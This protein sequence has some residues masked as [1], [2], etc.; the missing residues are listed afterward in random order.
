MRVVSTIPG[1]EPFTLEAGSIAVLMIHGF[2]GSPLSVKPWAQA[3]HA[4]GYTV[5]VPRLPGH[6]Q[7][8]EA[9]NETSWRDWY[10][11]VLNSFNSL[12]ARH[13]RVFVAGFSMGGALALHLAAKKGSE[14]EGLLLANPSVHDKRPMMRLVP[15]LKYFIPSVAGRGTDVAAP[16]PPKHSYGR[17]PL[18][19]LSS[20]Q[21]LWRIVQSELFAIDIPLMIGYSINDHVV[22]PANSETVIDNIS[23]VD[24]REVIFERSFHNVALDHDL[25]LLVE[26]ST[27]FISDVLTGAIEAPFDERELIDAEFEEIVA[28]FD[29]PSASAMDSDYIDQLEQIEAAERYTGDNKALPTLTR[30]QRAALVAV[31]AGPLYAIEV[32]FFKFDPLGLGYWPG[33]LSLLAGVALFFWQLRPDPDDGDGI[34]L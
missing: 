14:I 21:E 15:F 11:E 17:T 8:W 9:M 2:T 10:E 23:S 6:G 16:N 18:K 29:A 28:G 34:A 31:I 22:D 24:I 3:L 30:Q 19:A 33:L 25:D 27:T 4:H 20:L 1:S 5:A 13:E 12:R 32:R 26:A 7:T